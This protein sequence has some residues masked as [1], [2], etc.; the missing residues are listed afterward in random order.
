MENECDVL[1]VLRALFLFIFIEI[2]VTIRQSNATYDDSVV[3]VV[4]N[5]DDDDNH[6]RNDDFNNNDVYDDPFLM[7]I[8]TI[9]FI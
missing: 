5:N 7:M 2:I 4:D 8:T 1:D 6:D 3:V 9:S